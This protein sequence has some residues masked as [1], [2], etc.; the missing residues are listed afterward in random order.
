MQKKSHKSKFQVGQMVKISFKV[1]LSQMHN[2]L[3][4]M[5][6]KKFVIQKY[7][8][9]QCSN[10]N[11]R[12]NNSWFSASELEA[13]PEEETQEDFY[14][15]KETDGKISKILLQVLGRLPTDEDYEPEG[16]DYSSYFTCDLI[17]HF[18]EDIPGNYDHTT[19]V[20]EFLDNLGFD[21]MHDMFD[22]FDKFKQG[23]ER[24]SARFNWILF[25]LIMARE[26]GV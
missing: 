3:Q 20:M 16:E 15:E 13:V 9:W 17:N 6:D 11:Y 8:N 10:L 5:Q 22:K 19:I 21:H 4:E 1:D 18:S 25:A 7:T 24:Q 2:E 26:Q 12:V 23:F 14:T